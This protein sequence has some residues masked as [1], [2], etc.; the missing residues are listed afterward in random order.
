[1]YTQTKGL[2]ILGFG[3]MFWHSLFPDRIYSKIKT[4]NTKL[5][6]LEDNR[7]CLARNQSIASVKR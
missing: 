4:R 7:A 6:K 5:Q 3:S 1:V 2:V